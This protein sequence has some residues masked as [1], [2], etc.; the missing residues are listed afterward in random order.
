MAY[1]KKLGFF[2]R[3]ALKGL[4]I[5]GEVILLFKKKK[6]SFFFLLEG[7]GSGK[8]RVFGGL[9]GQGLKRGDVVG[10]RC[11]IFQDGRCAKHGILDGM[12]LNDGDIDGVGRNISDEENKGGIGGICSP[13]HRHE[14]VILNG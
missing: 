12:E 8:S 10:N 5:F 9:K 6:R 1:S 11:G 13:V 14:H 3:Q 7:M 4:T 2:F